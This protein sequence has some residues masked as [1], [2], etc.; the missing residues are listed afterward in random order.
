MKGTDQEAIDAIARATGSKKDANTAIGEL[1]LNGYEIV[2]KRNS[3]QH[4]DGMA[5]AED[6]LTSL[7]AML[8]SGVTFDAALELTDELRERL[9]HAGSTYAGETAPQNAGKD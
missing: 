5:I 6:V 8:H 3:E 2:R 7:E 1:T 4:E 9:E